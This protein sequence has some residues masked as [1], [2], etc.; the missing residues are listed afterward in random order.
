VSD[1]G[2]RDASDPRPPAGAG[3]GHSAEPGR[4]IPGMRERCGLL[5]GELTAER[6]PGGGFEVRARLA[7]A[8]AGSVHR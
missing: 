6:R 8:P 7:L 4:G 5:G 3:N 1:E 2:A